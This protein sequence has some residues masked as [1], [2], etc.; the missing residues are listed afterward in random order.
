MNDPAASC[1]ELVYAYALPI[2][3]LFSR[4]RFL[5][6]INKKPDFHLSNARLSKKSIPLYSPIGGCLDFKTGDY[7]F[8]KAILSCKELSE[9]TTCKG[10]TILLTL[11]KLMKVF[12]KKK[13]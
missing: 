9:L 6:A 11:I 8:I 4:V 5:K 13:M 12:V 3:I 10:S 2:Y 1:G 7:F